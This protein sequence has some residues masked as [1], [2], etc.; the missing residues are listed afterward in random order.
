MHTGAANSVKRGRS[1]MNDHHRVEQLRVLIE[2]LQRM[3][4]SPKRDW[5]LSQVRSRTV[6]VESGVRP[7]P[8]PPRT[9]DEPAPPREPVG[10]T[11]ASP[12]A[13][14]AEIHSTATEPP[15]VPAPVDAPRPAPRA[16]TDA[17]ID[18][19]EQ[20]GVLCLGDLPDAPATETHHVV[21]PPWAR[22]LRG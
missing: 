6:D 5:M 2:R 21:S 17:P 10:R 12:P 11:P 15:V 7:E 13:A 8:I 22:G 14:P 3:P 4:A 20:A 9:L 19:L 16:R 1:H 18:L